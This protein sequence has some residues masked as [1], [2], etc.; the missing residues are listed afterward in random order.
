MRKLFLGLFSA[1]VL[2]C[3]VGSAAAQAHTVTFTWT[4]PTTRVGGAALPLSSIGG[5]VVYDTSLP[6]PGVPGTVVA[7]PVTLPP[8]TATGTCTTGTVA[9]GT[10]VFVA[11][12]SDNATPPDASAV[13]N[14]ASAVIALA[15]P[16][17][18]TNLTA[19]VN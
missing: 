3:G 18:I 5:F 7:C 16:V 1:A 2:L 6:A 10:H 13:S 17:A 14:S 12:V 4:W 9:A 8:T 19:T 15:G 11:V